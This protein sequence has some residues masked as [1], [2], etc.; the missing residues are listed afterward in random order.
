MSESDSIKREKSRQRET[1][2]GLIIHPPATSQFEKTFK[3]TNL[4]ISF[5]SADFGFTNPL[6]GWI[7]RKRKEQKQK[8]EDRKFP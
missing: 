7:K 2:D 3:Q 6:L 5:N 1:V 8:R 4:F